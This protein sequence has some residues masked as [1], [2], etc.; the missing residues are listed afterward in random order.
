MGAEAL[1]AIAWLCLSPRMEWTRGQSHSQPTEGTH[2]R[3]E[4]T[5]RPQA[6]AD[7]CTLKNL[8]RL[9]A[10]SVSGPVLTPDPPV[11]PSLGEVGRRLTHVSQLRKQRLRGVRTP[12]SN[13]TTG[14]EFELRQ[15]L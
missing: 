1:R 14:P 10:P 11:P 9:N 6:E 4:E 13:N 5:W 8:H 7:G 15:T 3:G 12:A 2:R